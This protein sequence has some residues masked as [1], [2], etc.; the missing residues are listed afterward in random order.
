MSLLRSFNSTHIKAERKDA[1][2]WINEICVFGYPTFLH[3]LLKFRQIMYSF[4]KEIAI[5]YCLN[6]YGEFDI[7]GSI[8]YKNLPVYIHER[9]LL[10]GENAQ[11]TPGR[12]Q[13]EVYLK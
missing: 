7:T 13:F 10:F 8:G 5:S 12:G 2:T 11:Y 6:M 1:Y 9:T 4:Q 3:R